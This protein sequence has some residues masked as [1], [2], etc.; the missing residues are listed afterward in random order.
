[1]S[2]E[3]YERGRVV[4]PTEAAQTVHAALIEIANTIR[5]AARDAIRQLPGY[6]A[7]D[8]DWRARRDAEQRWR[9]DIE[10]TQ[11][12]VLCWLTLDDIQQA[13]EHDE[14]PV[15]IVDRLLPTATDETK[16]FEAGF[17]TITIS[18]RGVSWWAEGNRVH[19][20]LNDHPVVTSLVLV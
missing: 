16:R 18:D 7:S 8:M 5:Q 12:D 3:E 11:G 14:D 1:M 17:T 2:C 6:Y 13:L 4:L 10:K 9:R 19:E 20:T 15:A